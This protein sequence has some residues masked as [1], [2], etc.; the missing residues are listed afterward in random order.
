M[1]RSCDGLACFLAHPAGQ[2]ADTRSFH[3]LPLS[4]GRF[5]GLRPVLV[6]A[7]V[8]SSIPIAGKFAERLQFL[9]PQQSRL[10]AEDLAD[11]VAPFVQLHFH[12]AL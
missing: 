6:K 10:A 12:F 1:G 9:Q 5:V 11:A 2:I 8:D 4:G 3:P 7:D